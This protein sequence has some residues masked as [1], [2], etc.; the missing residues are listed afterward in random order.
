VGSG[1]SRGFKASHASKNGNLN[2]NFVY[3]T[4]SFS[5]SGAAGPAERITGTIER[6]TYDGSIYLANEDQ[7]VEVSMGTPNS[8]MKRGLA[9]S[10]LAIGKTVTVD[11]YGSVSGGS[12]LYARRIMIDGRIINLKT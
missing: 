4:G 10:D 3:A 11:A 7:R 1:L 5:S 8:M 2:R 6:T 12:K 9:F